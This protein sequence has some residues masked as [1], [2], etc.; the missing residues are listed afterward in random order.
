VEQPT[1]RRIRPED[2]ETVGALVMRAYDGVGAFED[3]YRDFLHRPDEWVPGTSATFVATLDERIV[4]SVGFVRPGDEEFEDLLMEPGDCGFRFL[5]VDPDAQGRGVG[6]LL[7]DRCLE[8]ARA[9]GCHR[10]FIHSME[11]MTAA[12]ALYERRGFVRRPDIDVRFP[13]GIGRGFALDLTEEASSRFGSPGPTPDEPP[14]YQ[15]VWLDRADA[16]ANPTC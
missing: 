6:G 7:V 10:M 15:E 13:A 14:W 4:G 16:D 12:H 3:D 11:F 2:H 1:I 5:A 9:S 8:E